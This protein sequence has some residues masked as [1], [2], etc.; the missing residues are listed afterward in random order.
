MKNLENLTGK[1][2]REEEFL[3]GGNGENRG[4]GEYFLAGERRVSEGRF[5][6]EHRGNRESRQVGSQYE[7][8]SSSPRPSPPLRGREGGERR[9]NRDG[10]GIHNNNSSVPS[11]TSCSIR[12]QASCSIRPRGSCSIHSFHWHYRRNSVKLRVTSRCFMKE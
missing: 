4:C 9:E 8:D 10:L 7:I 11:V 6:G 5:T 2:G 3:T 12:P 1:G